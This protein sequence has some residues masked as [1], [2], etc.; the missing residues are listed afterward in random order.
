MLIRRFG[1]D[2]GLDFLIFT[3][4]IVWQSLS[5]SVVKISIAA[6]NVHI[7]AFL[8]QIAIGAIQAKKVM[9]FS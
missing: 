9:S 3:T 1:E 8:L 2:K 4:T 5:E 6:V 7:T